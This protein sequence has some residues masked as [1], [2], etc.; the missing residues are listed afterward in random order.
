MASPGEDNLQILGILSPEVITQRITFSWFG[1]G[2]TNC[3]VVGSRSPRRSHEKEPQRGGEALSRHVAQGWCLRGTLPPAAHLISAA[4][5]VFT[6]FIIR[7]QKE[8]P[9]GGCAI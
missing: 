1:R 6:H 3:L 7:V 8:Q 2:F 5:Y 9:T 4:N